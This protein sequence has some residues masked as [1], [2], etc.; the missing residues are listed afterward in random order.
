MS[1]RVRK[2]RLSDHG[3]S[4]RADDGE[5]LRVM[6]VTRKYPTVN[7]P[8]SNVFTHRAI[9]ALSSKIEIEV[10]DLCPWKRGQPFISHRDYDG[11][12][13]ISVACPTVPWLQTPR[14]N[15]LIQIYFGMYLARSYLRNVDIVH[16]AA[17]YPA[18]LIAAQ[19]ARMARKPCTT[20]AI[21]SDVNFLP[22]KI[23][24]SMFFRLPWHLDGIACESE[25]M[26]K[27][28]TG[29]FPGSQ[30]ARVIYRGV[31]T[32]KFSPRSVKSNDSIPPSHLSFLFLG[33][34]HSWDENHLSYNVKGGPVMLEAWRQI[35]G[36]IAPDTLVIGGPRTDIYRPQ[37]EEWR[38]SLSRSDS[39]SFLAAIPPD[40]V[41]AVIRESDVV[42]IPSL[43]EG[44]PN[45][46]K[47]AQAC[48]KP[49][50]GTDAGGIPEA[51]LHGKTGLIVPRG[52]VDALASGF[53]WFHTHRN[54]IGTMGLQARNHML[55]EF[56]WNQFS[57]NM[58]DFFHTAIEIHDPT[59]DLSRAADL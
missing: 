43:F 37:L 33:G 29:L 35:E 4:E 21:G 55:R 31:D 46:A 44:L 32:N 2:S 39:V 34:F 20:H 53:L 10:M 6:F 40:A 58:L 18:G 3:F 48:G 51:V 24:D 42:V 11:V 52:D 1:K 17:F 25:E 36:K 19:W 7:T 50:L 38:L 5:R 45:L 41:P 56:S 13:V 54:V 57:M 16:G 26:M 49:V 27:K 9:K 12:H 22:R 59:L 14:I 28:V 30:N 47:E 15:L 23:L 8:H